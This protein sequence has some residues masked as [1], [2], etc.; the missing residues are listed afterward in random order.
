[1]RFC[2]IN[3]VILIMTASEFVHN[4]IQKLFID[5]VN[6]VEKKSIVCWPVFSPA[7]IEVYIC[8]CVC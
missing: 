1:M 5:P 2:N 4:K 6:G 7:N 8:T 3:Y